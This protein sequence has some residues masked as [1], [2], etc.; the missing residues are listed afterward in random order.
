[1]Y[2][3]IG[4]DDTVNSYKRLSGRIHPQSTP[5]FVLIVASA[6][7]LGTVLKCSKSRVQ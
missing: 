6:T 3:K 1:M 7:K 4:V 2:V 5:A